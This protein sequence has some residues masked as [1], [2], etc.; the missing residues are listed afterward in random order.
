MY[1]GACVC[2]NICAVQRQQHNYL[3]IE[4]GE[5]YK[6]DLCGHNAHAWA[7]LRK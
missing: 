2:L 3:F 7:L 4:E 5:T 6:N 1:M